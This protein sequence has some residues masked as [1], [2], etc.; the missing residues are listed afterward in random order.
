MKW[1]WS[2]ETKYQRYIDL[3]SLG[4]LRAD[5][6]FNIEL[7]VC[8]YLNSLYNHRC[9]R[10]DTHSLSNHHNISQISTH[11]LKPNP[12]DH[13]KASEDIYDARA[14]AFSPQF[15]FPAIRNEGRF[16]AMP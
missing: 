7:F 3:V 9:D 2:V 10:Y 11:S 14:R 16:Q 5:N 12:R 4:G 13:Y 15:S 6:I 8:V 1:T